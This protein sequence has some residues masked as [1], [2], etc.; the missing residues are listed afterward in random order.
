VSSSSL[1][2]FYVGLYGSKESLCLLCF[3]RGLL[4]LESI[5]VDGRFTHHLRWE[6]SHKTLFCYLI[7]STVYGFTE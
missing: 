3:C 5:R 1:S 6:G 7:S 2:L 4:I